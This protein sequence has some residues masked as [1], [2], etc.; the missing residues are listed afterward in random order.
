MEEKG[1]LGKPEEFEAE[2]IITRRKKEH[3]EHLDSALT[4]NSVCFTA[5]IQLVGTKFSI[6]FLWKS[7]AF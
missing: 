2:I 4:N 1:V 5:N 6:V 3:S 7:V